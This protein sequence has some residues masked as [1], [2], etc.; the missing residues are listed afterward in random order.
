MCE[1]AASQVGI[2]WHAMSSSSTRM[3]EGQTQHQAADGKKRKHLGRAENTPAASSGSSFLLNP[4]PMF[5]ASGG[6]PNDHVSNHSMSHRSGTC[7][8]APWHQPP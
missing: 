7:C 2:E 4:L 3:T 1:F 8:M 5:L 6:L